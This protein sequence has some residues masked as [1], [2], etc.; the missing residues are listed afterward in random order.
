MMTVREALI[1]WYEILD[2]IPAETAIDTQEEGATPGAGASLVI[3]LI[4]LPGDKVSVLAVGA[5]LYDGKPRVFAE[6]FQGKGAV[7][8]VAVEKFREGLA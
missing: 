6:C 3:S 7:V 1:A 8:A 2:S 5:G 4:V